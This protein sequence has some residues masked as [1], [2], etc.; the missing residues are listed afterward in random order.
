MHH[1]SGEPMH[2][3]S[4]VDSG[5]W[6][7]MN[8]LMVDEKR[9][10]VDP[11]H[12]GMMRAVEKWGPIAS[13]T[14]ERQVP[15]LSGLWPVNSSEATTSIR[16]R[17]LRSLADQIARIAGAFETGHA[18]HEFVE[19]GARLVGTPGQFPAE[20]LAPPVDRPIDG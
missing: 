9:V 8:V 5:R 1:L 13:G 15:D 7:N 16:G 19:S 18:L 17:R 6:L 3:F 10:I 11:H 2:D 4:G 14:P 12:T 20:N